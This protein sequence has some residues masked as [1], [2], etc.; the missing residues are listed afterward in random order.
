MLCIGLEIVDTQ[1]IYLRP[2]AGCPYSV[3][4]QVINRAYIN[5]VFI[6]LAENFTSN[7]GVMIKGLLTIG[8]G[9]VVTKSILTVWLYRTS[10]STRIKY[11]CA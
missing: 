2:S 9:L 4:S 10:P 1:V 7:A 6:V 8:K 3:K 5:R 11:N